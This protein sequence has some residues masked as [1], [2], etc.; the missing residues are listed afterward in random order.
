ME[1]ECHPET[2]SSSSSDST[3]FRPQLCLLVDA[4]GRTLSFSAARESS[5][6]VHTTVVVKDQQYRLLAPD[7]TT[8]VLGALADLHVSSVSGPGDQ[9]PQNPPT[10]GASYYDTVGFEDMGSPAC[11][12][13][14]QLFQF[15]P[16]D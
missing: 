5:G 13:C 6:N 11:A 4:D 16:P 15:S 2:S 14:Q 9:L 3:E 8:W 1:E 12:V 7:G 10:D